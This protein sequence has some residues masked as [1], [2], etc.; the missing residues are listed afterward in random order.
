VAPAR[1]HIASILAKLD[2]HSSYKRSFSG[3]ATTSSKSASGQR[4]ALSAASRR[5]AEQGQRFH[6]VELTAI[7][8]TSGTTG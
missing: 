1:N 7:V 4:G 3:C 5:S 2:A 8:M 6:V